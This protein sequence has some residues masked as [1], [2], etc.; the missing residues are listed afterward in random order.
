M[1]I[2]A[3][4]LPNPWLWPNLMT[5]SSIC[6][7]NGNFG[8]HE[9]ALLISSA[10]ENMIGWWPQLLFLKVHLMFILMLHLLPFA[11]IQWLIMARQHVRLLQ[12][13]FWL[14]DS[15]WPDQILLDLCYSLRLF[16]PNFSSLSLSYHSCQTYIMIWSLPSHAAAYL[17]NTPLAY[18]T[19]FWHLL[20]CGPD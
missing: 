7:R 10:M 1:W 15:Y 3:I 12:C 2:Q 14:K 4:W 17:P 19:L 18:L 16:L 20:L 13:G 8:V 11:P 9:N 6:S 5:M